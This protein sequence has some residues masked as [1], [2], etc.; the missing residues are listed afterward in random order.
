M[1]HDRTPRVLRNRLLARLAE[2]DFR[3]LAA[4]FQPV[5]LQINQ[6]IYELHGTIDR[7]YFP[8][9][10]VMSALA[11]MEDGNAIEVATIG[12]EGLVGHAVASDG[13][14][15]PNRVIVQI[16]GA[17]W[18]I[19]AA[20]LRE[21]VARSPALKALLNDYHTAFMAQVSQSVACNGLHRLEQRACRWLLMSRDRVDSD[22][23][24]LTHDFLAIMLGARRASITELLRPLQEANLV[25]SHRGRITIVD[26]GGLRGPLLRM[27][28]RRPRRVRPP[29][30][31]PD[32]KLPVG[33]PA[34]ASWLRSE[35]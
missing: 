22:D 7:A 24:H 17:G 23:L 13:A 34:P 28:P 29:P 33:T 15:S 25:R 16:A 1:P 6:V 21:Q 3:P 2:D 20:A 10:A 35:S 4:A 18:R 27:L 32:L 12:K 19:E 9:G 11:V 8:A 26:G 31:P 30:R 5:D 14:R